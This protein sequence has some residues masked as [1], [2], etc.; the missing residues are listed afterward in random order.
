[1]Q[2]QT[3]DGQTLLDQVQAPFDGPLFRLGG[4][5][6]YLAQVI[7]VALIIAVTVFVSILVRRLLLR[8]FKRRGVDQGVS[9]AINR[10]VHYAILALGFFLA[11]DNIGVSL[12]GFAAFG[13]IVGV[14]IGFGLQN[15][16]Q[17]FVSGLILLLERPVKRGDFVLVGKD[18]A[19]RGTVRDIR[20]RA[21]VVTTLDGMDILV[22]NSHFINEEVVNQTYGDRRLRGRVNVGVAYG[23]DTEKVRSILERVAKAHAEVLDDPAPT[24]RFMDFGDSSLDFSV[25]FWIN[26][27]VRVVPVESDIRF[28]IDGAFREHDVEIPFPQRDLHMR[29]GW[30][31]P[32]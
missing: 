18:S 9:Y 28:A 30:P 26:N 8:T 29:S 31:Q 27:P 4:E 32:N 2:S 25:F 12:T 10:L 23:S 13:A 17:N 14:G 6:I 16:A 24:V 1:M 15:I 19:V 20:A 11:L 5:E 7:T 3:D 21:T 22:P